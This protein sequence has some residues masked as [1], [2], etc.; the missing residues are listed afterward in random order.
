MFNQSI[1][2]SIFLYVIVVE[3]HLCGP[4]LI[5]PLSIRL[6]RQLR[7]LRLQ[8]SRRR[9]NGTLIGTV[10]AQRRSLAAALRCRWRSL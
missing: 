3:L 4:R 5:D 9:C 2:Q 8:P 10:T 6:A 1:D 7:A